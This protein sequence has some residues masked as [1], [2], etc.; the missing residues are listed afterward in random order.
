MTPLAVLL[1]IKIIGTSLLVSIPFLF[2]PQTRLETM[3]RV[4]GENPGLF[5]L[6]GV[7]ITSLLVCYAFGLLSELNGEFPY[8]AVV[9]G[10]FSNGGAATLLSRYANKTAVN[11][12]LTTFFGSI[13]AL[14]SIALIGVTY[15]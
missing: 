7:A 8:Y 3:F 10:I 15:G 2:L 6:Y 4:Q 13:A 5:R 14:L 1:S 12:I 11:R 9:T